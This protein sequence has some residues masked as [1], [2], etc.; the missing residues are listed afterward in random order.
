MT[1]D[2]GWEEIYN[3]AGWLLA[4]AGTNGI[5]G[6]GRRKV[7]LTALGKSFESN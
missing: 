7:A 1:K 2:L 5:T 6:N 3:D 4:L